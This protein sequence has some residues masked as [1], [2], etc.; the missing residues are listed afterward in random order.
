RPAA[1]PGTPL[2]AFVRAHPRDGSTVLTE[3]RLVMLDPVNH[4][5]TPLAPDPAV[6]G[7]L[8]FLD[9]RTLVVEGRAVWT[10]KLRAKIQ[11]T[12]ASTQQGGSATA[13]PV[14]EAVPT[15][16][17]TVQAP[18]PAWTFSVEIPDGWQRVPLP[19]DEPDFDDMRVMRP[20]VVYMAPYA[21]ILFTVAVRPCPPGAVMPG[22]APAAMLNFLADAQ[23]MK[24]EN[25]GD[26]KL[27]AG[28][29]AVA[30][31]RQNS[32]AGPMVFRLFLLEHAGN[33]FSLTSMAPQPLWA[34]T[35]ETLEKIV[36]SFRPRTGATP[37]A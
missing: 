8:R 5:V 6:V 21:P 35:Q 24:V 20:L 36:E 18:Q 25:P 3:N 37:F 19:P 32:D 33:L 28:L 31:A 23:G 12:G 4:A 30:T 1:H 9:D 14:A 22:A 27:P 17:V 16:R 26:V 34:A 13:A 7:N 10:I 11:E 2:I 29:A 15:S